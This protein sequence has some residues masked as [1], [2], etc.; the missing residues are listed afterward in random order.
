MNQQ[1]SKRFTR[2]FHEPPTHII[3]APGRINLMGDHTDYNEGWVLPVALN[4]GTTIAA[5]R[6]PD[7]LLHTVTLNLGQQEDQVSLDNL[8][9]FEGEQWTW[10]IRGVA[11]LLQEIG[12]PIGGA[13]ILI[14]GDLPI[15]VGLSSSA[16]LELG[17][18]VALV[19]LAGGTI[20]RQDRLSLVRLSQRVEHAI[21]GMRCGLME[22]LAVACSAPAH[23]LLI[24]S[25][26]LEMQTIPV[27]ENV[28]ILVID[29][30]IPTPH[31]TTTALYAERRS[32]CESAVH[33]L[34]DFHPTIRALRD[35]ALRVLMKE[36]EWLTATEFRR[37]RH[38]V[39]EN[40]RV[41][42]GISFLQ[43]R[44]LA[45]FGHL[46]DLS[47]ASLRDDYEVSCSEIDALVDITRDTVGV[48]G[49]RLSGLGRGGCVVALVDEQHA[50]RA[51]RHITD[52]YH[53]TT[54]HIVTAH[55]CVPS[56]GAICTTE[57]RERKNR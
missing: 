41:L 3:Q 14:S 17:I 13:N 19:S 44:K 21:F 32:E 49:A 54:G 56:S 10:Y 1:L 16:S 15:G 50:K 2:F 43:Q 12:Y 28:R 40:Q 48:F 18:A 9:P 52:V 23:A 6:R 55:V 27:P 51:T 26:T 47:H 39:T 22:Q 46:M 11:S 25:R 30:H 7:R 42:Q 31:P 35:V 34:H 24:D 36:Q 37:A 38:V 20:D 33:K 4:L 5:R 45:A 57:E 29:S 8:Q 53:R